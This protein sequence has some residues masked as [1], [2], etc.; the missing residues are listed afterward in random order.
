M[1]NIKFNIENIN[2]V[3]DLDE[4]NI[5][6]KIDENFSFDLKYKG[7]GFRLPDQWTKI[8]NYKHY[9]SIP[10][11]YCEIGVFN[12]INFICVEKIFGNHSKTEMVAIDPWLNYDDYPEYK[13]K[14]MQSIYDTA[15]ENMKKNNIDMNKVKIMREFSHKA[16]HQLQDEYFDIIYIDGNH[17]PHAVMEDAVLYFRKLK[18]GGIMIFDDIHSDWMDV[19]TAATDFSKN[20]RNKMK[21]ITIHNSQLYLE[22]IKL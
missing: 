11:K 1:E 4:K 10:I 17:E 2:F 8:L 7:Q 6:V 3:L 16:A 13:D 14:N 22:K 18:L 12:G 21:A 20:Y 19:V 15:I 5:N 9:S